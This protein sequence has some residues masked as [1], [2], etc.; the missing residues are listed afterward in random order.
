MTLNVNVATGN[1]VIP[2]IRTVNLVTTDGR[3]CQGRARGDW[4]RRL[5][6]GGAYGAHELSQD[7]AE[8]LTRQTVQTQ[9]KLAARAGLVEGMVPVGDPR[10]TT[11]VLETCGRRS[12]LQVDYLTGPRYLSSQF[13]V[14][15]ISSGLGTL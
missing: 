10:D 12:V 4:R 13:S 9:A 8:P 1:T 3:L 6:S 11:G 2:E 15:L 14:S 7:N 5:R